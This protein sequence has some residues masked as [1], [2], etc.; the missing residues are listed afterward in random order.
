[1]N[2][3]YSVVIISCILSLVSLT[4]DIG[5]NTLLS[6]TDIKWF[7]FT[8]ILVAVGAFCEW[9]GE[10]LNN[11]FLHLNIL[12]S[13]ITLF[14][15]CIT[16]YLSVFMARS[17]GMR[18][19]TRHFSIFM[20]TH[21]LF[22]IIAI[23]FGLVFYISPEGHAERGPIFLIYL[24]VCLV[25]FVYILVVFFLLGKSTEFKNPLSLLLIAV[26]MIFGQVAG[27]INEQILSGYISITFTTI[28]LYN[29]I[30]IFIRHQMLTTIG[31]EQEIANH[32]SLTGVSSRICFEDKSVKLNSQIRADKENTK[33]AICECD[34][35]NLKYINDSFGHDMGDTY[36][37]SCCKV[38]CDIFKHSQVFR[39][40][41]DEFV[42]LIL[43]DEYQRL[44]E[45]KAEVQL[46]QSQE[47]SKPGEFFERRSFAA[48]FSSFD[49]EIDDNVASVLKRADEDMYDNKKMIKTLMFS[50]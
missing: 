25:S 3:L 22:E 17:C 19:G 31:L 45:L 21:A 5:K 13:I 12:H 40:G 11:S 16:P 46:F 14:E 43:N 7:K 29:Y 18:R 35:N 23:H 28:L 15:F 20:G 27:A 38:I 37:R 44:E 4:I 36:I 2:N 10:V 1:M 33:F 49:Y 32:D 6:K 42:I 48:G 9:L 47:A 30:Q 26:V 24:A 34:L 41:G 50:N 39:I 8:F